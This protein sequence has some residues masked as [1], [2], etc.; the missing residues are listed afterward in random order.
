MEIPYVVATIVILIAILYLAGGALAENCADI[1]ECRQCWKT[2]PVVVKSD[3]CP[4]S[5]ECIASPRA[6]QNNAIVSA[7]MCGCTFAKQENYENTL[8]NRQIEETVSNY[9]GFNMTVQ[10]I[11]EQTGMF[12]VKTN[13]D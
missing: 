13:Y 10:S 9:N 5:S 2:T 1:S 4:N 3:L 8:R 6:Q 7:V 12:L 11:C